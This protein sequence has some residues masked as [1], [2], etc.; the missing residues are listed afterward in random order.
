M[1]RAK[2]TTSFAAALILAITLIGCGQEVDPF[3]SPGNVTEAA[4]IIRRSSLG[5][6]LVVFT[7]YPLHKDA[8]P[9]GV[10]AAALD[11]IGGLN[12]SAA[13]FHWSERDMAERWIK[14]Q[15]DIRRSQG[16]APQL[17]LAGHSLGATTAAET[18]RDVLNRQPDVIIPL[19]LTV[20]AIKTG[21]IVSKA[22]VTGAIIANSVPG[23]KTNFTSYDSAP[24]PDNV[25]FL[26][27]MNYY[28]NNSSLY[29]GVAMPGAENRLLTDSTTLLNHGNADDFCYPFMVREFR[30]VLA[31]RTM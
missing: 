1:I 24:Y 7:P 23:I 11:A 10:H 30:F 17:I 18:A 2:K 26:R 31:G 15:T 22:G 29:H 19:L 5:P 21:R 27:H 12:C 13:A 3:P 25:R 8:P 6:I 9:D 28:Q 14:E 16:V 4:I 20:D